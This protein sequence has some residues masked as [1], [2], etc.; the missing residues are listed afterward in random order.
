VQWIRSVA[1]VSVEK[2]SIVQLLVKLFVTTSVARILLLESGS[3]EPQRPGGQLTPL[4]RVRGPHAAFDPTVCQLFRLWPP[5]FVTLRG[6]WLVLFWSL[7]KRWR[8]KEYVTYF[9]RYFQNNNNNNSKVSYY[10]QFITY[11]QN[12]FLGEWETRPLAP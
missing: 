10:P 3:A 1:V 6:L 8:I 7:S 5:L 12:K 2:K 11:F 4:F 9:D